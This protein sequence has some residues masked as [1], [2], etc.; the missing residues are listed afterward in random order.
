VNQTTPAPARERVPL[1]EKLAL[2]IPEASALANVCRSVVY[3]AVSSGALRARKRGRS[4]LIL[5]NDLREWVDTFPVFAPS[6]ANNPNAGKRR[7][8]VAAEAA[9]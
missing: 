5:Q 6:P 2:T 3:Q 1:N 8:V 9:A 4:T 7:E